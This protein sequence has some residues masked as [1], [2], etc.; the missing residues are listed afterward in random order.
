MACVVAIDQGTT[1][2]TVLVL[3]KRGRV[4]ARAYSE[5]T[6]YYPKPGWVEHD[7]EEIWRVTL[8]VLRKAVKAA[9]LKAKDVAAIG[10]T[11]QRETTV[12]WDRKTGKPIHRAIVW[13]DRRTADL[14]EELKSAGHDAT[15]R[16]KT[17]LLL[18]PYFSGTKVRWL[19]DRVKGAREKAA[20][21]GLCF[22]TI[23][24]W[25]VWKLTGGGVHVTDPTNASRTLLFDI[26][27]RSWDAELLSMLDVPAGVLP[28][29][30]P[31]SGVFG[32]TTPD[33]LGAPVKIAGIAGDQQAALFGQG[34]V[35]AGRA[36]N[37]YGTGCFLL[38]NTGRS[39]GP[40]ALRAS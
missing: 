39:R 29:V 8:A 21:G 17:G 5:F 2:S 20:A 6:Q 19:L 35:D 10:I 33:V 28:A 24:T 37:T 11:N 31:S 26:H 18:D 25:L 14:C 27:T 1:G 4:V 15:V 12:L 40:V 30:A 13:Q 16:A 22:G 7:A 32:E 34:C 36:K 23:D 9:K 3:D 38:L